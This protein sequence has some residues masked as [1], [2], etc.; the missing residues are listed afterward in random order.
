MRHHGKAQEMVRK[1]KG[2]S[3]IPHFDG[4]LPVDGEPISMTAWFED[5][6]ALVAHSH[7]NASG[8]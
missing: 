6:A 7:R 8:L 1:R 4:P 5:R 3:A 2:A